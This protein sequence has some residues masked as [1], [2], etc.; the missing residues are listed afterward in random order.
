MIHIDMVGIQYLGT[1]CQ[2]LQAEGAAV[3]WE[4]CHAN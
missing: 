1:F 4:A 2:E 3:K